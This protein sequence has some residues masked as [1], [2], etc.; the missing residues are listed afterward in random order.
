MS[1][2]D[3]SLH[4][5]FHQASKAG[6]SYDMRNIFQETLVNAMPQKAV[7][8]VANHDTQ[9][10]QSLEAPVEA[11]FKPIAYALI[12]LRDEGYP[13]V[14]YPDLYGAH[15]KGGGK[16]GKEYEI[17]LAKVDEL[18]NLLHARNQH[19]YGI[20]RDY[21]DH[22]NCIGWAREGDEGHSGCAVV[23]SNGDNGNKTME[24]GKRYAGKK[25]I[26]MLGKNPAEVEIN[27]DGWGEFF[28]PAGSVS[29]WIEKQN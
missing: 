29:V 25:F 7:T 27:R 12:L 19:A 18:E 8:V 23:L 16:D 13:C 28:A 2:F 20:Q 21:F 10:L 4:Q 1:L 14:F 5:N 17:W 26:D 6:N 24:I 15:Y 11:W 9:P 3:S 22:A